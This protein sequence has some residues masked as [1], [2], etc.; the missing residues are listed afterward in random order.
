M[1][2]RSRRALVDHVE[3]RLRRA[4]HSLWL[5]KA[6]S[7][8]EGI[9][10]DGKPT[11]QCWP[12]SRL[13]IGARFYLAS[14]PEESHM[15]LGADA[16]VR[17][18]D[19]VWIGHGASISANQLVSIGDGTRLGPF[20]TIMDTDF[21]VAGDRSAAPQA[22]PI[23]IGR[24]VLVGTGATILRGTKIGDGARIE[25]SA[26]VSGDVAA[27]TTV[28]GVPA[29]VLGRRSSAHTADVT[30]VVMR[31]LGLA[32]PPGP[33]DG[34]RNLPGWDSLGALK[35]LL[36]LEDEFEVTL[37]EQE[38][39]RVETMNDVTVLVERARERAHDAAMGA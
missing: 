15:V 6:T 9:R 10:L 30:D 5:R 8:G 32:V 22:T 1:S 18:G 16:E 3:S 13:V 37:R 14:M 35:L 28:G 11:F 21:H 4:R 26:V 33:D 17:I 25:A 20:V 24:N 19:D 31:V 34:P 2:E 12:K 36:A 27:G 23:V 39:L 38:L 7:V 29:R